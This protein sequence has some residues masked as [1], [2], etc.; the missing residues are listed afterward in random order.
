VVALL[1]L[2]TSIIS[3]IDASAFKVAASS[4]KRASG[5]ASKHYIQSSLSRISNNK[6]KYPNALNK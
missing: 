6:E 1:A 4:N 2:S 5:Y 3:Y